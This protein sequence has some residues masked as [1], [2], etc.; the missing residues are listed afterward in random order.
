VVYFDGTTDLSD[1]ALG[2]T[3]GTVWTTLE[4]LTLNDDYF[5]LTMNAGNPLI[6]LSSSTSIV[7]NRA[8]DQLNFTIA[9]NGVLQLNST[10]VNSFNPLYITTA[11]NSTST[12]T[13]ALRVTGGVGIGGNLYVGGEIVAQK[14]TIELTT[15]TTT[16]VK[17]DDIIQ[18][19]NATP[20]ISTSTG[21][22]IVSGGV[23]VG[24]ALYV[25]SRVALDDYYYLTMNGN[26][27]TLALSSSSAVAFDR[28]NNQLNFT[29]NSNGVFQLSPTYVNAIKPLVTPTYTVGTLPS[30]V[31]GM[32]AFVS[33][34]NTGT[35]YSVAAGG[36]S[37]MVPVY[38]TGSEWRIG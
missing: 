22:L 29:V 33:D 3:T 6:A 27:P 9:N 38:Y 14:L 20:S 16:L 18:T 15:I 31:Q 34:A 25:K 23:G 5:Y 7:Y 30:G 12:T 4:R 11:T 32:R 28:T 2:R 8:T 19:T 26:N 13:G 36:G 24:G 10:Y 1:N 17:T 35:F 21:A 37:F